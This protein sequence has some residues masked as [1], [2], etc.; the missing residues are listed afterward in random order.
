M[1]K[2]KSAAMALSIQLATAHDLAAIFELMRHMQH[3]DP[4]S[5]AFDEPIVRKNLHDL[6]HNPHFGLIYLVR[7]NQNPVAYL[8]ICFDFSLEYRGKGA[9]IDE[10]FVEASHRGQGIGTQLLDLA[11]RAS[12]EHGAQFLHLEVNHGNPANELYRRRGFLDH[13]RFL[14]TKPLKVAQ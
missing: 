14:M 5:E 8:V 11:E 12:P 4:W 7:E 13:N 9:W 1:P 10:L 2:V 6:L 3:D